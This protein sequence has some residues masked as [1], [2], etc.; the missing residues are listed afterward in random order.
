MTNR[1]PLP[2]ALKFLLVGAAAFYAVFIGRTAFRVDGRVFFTLIDD[3]MI[4]MRYAQHLASGHGLIWNVGE[5]PVQGFTNLGWMLFMALLHLLPFSMAKISLGIM[6]A[7]AAVLL[8]NVIVVHRVCMAVDPNA[9]FAPLLAAAT[10]AFYFPLVFWSLRGMEVGLLVLLVDLAMLYSMHMEPRR[11]RETAL[12]GLVLATA[13]VVRMDAAPQVAVIVIYAI[14]ARK[15]SRGQA[16]ALL[17]AVLVTLICILAFQKTYFGDALPNTYYQKMVGGSM[18]DRIRYGIL[19]F[20]NYASRD[21]LMM[22]LISSAGIWLYRDLRSP[23]A[24]LLAGLFTVQCMYS[25]WVGG[26]Y[27]EPELASANRFI[28]QG[29]PA[30]IILFSLT[31]DHII[32]DALAAR[33]KLLRTHAPSATMLSLAGALATVLVISGTPWLNWV[34]DD[35][36]LLKSDIRRVRAGLA[37][38]ETTAPTTTIAVHAAGQIPYYSGR[39]TIDLL[40]LNDPIIAKSPRSTAFYPGHDKWNYE[41]SI[42][43]QKPDLIA[44]NWIRLGDFIR[45]QPDYRQ[46]ENGMYIRVDSTLVDEV[47]LLSAFP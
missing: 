24:A 27:A 21:V 39:R 36:P 16:A 41:Y 30:L 42:A 34:I 12:L 47:A 20:N 44:D 1:E 7:S 35:A 10:A 23:N 2:T 32:R 38:A 43:Q 46:L 17:A 6:V 45:S 29:M 5:A 18:G 33:R 13:L 37:I 11:F 3:A 4:S 26:D 22:A 8:F 9:R 31:I 15:M 40:G 25:I 19:V 14:A 28:T